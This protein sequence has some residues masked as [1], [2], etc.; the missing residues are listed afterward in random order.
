MYNARDKENTLIHSAL[1]WVQTGFILTL[2]YL[3]PKSEVWIKV[4]DFFFFF[5]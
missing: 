4:N 2:E 3:P 1:I 5:F